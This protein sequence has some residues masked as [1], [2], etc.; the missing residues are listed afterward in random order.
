MIVHADCDFKFSAAAASINDAN[1]FSKSHNKIEQLLVTFYTQFPFQKTKHCCFLFS[2][3]F[4]KR[5]Q[6]LATE[7]DPQTLF[8]PFWQSFITSYPDSQ[9]RYSHNEYL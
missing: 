9:L 5:W 7:N 8:P 1:S 6:W 3:H 2:R 4:D